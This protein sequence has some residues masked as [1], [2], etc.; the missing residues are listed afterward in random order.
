[1]LVDRVWG[2]GKWSSCLTGIEFQFFKM[3][4]VQELVAQWCECTWYHWILH[5]KIVKDGKFYVMYTLPQLKIKQA[6][7]DTTLHSLGWL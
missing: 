7:W 4:R 6:Q 2:K 5:F 3:K 1:M